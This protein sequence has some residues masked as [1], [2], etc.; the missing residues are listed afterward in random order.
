LYFDF[1]GCW[2]AAVVSFDYKKTPKGLAHA[3]EA[4]FT[5]VAIDI[6]S[7][8]ALGNNKA[9]QQAARELENTIDGV[10]GP[11]T[12][13]LKSRVNDAVLNPTGDGYFLGF[14]EERITDG[15]VLKYA[16][17]ISN[18]LKERKLPVR[19]GINK[20]YCFVYR[21]LNDKLNMCGWG[22]IDAERVMSF[23][24][25]N[26][27]LCTREFVKAYVDRHPDTKSLFHE[28]GSLTSKGRK[29][30]V[31]NYYKNHTYGSGKRPKKR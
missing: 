4:Q 23:G 19:M 30:D 13:D 6:V 25:K 7:F 15:E 11:V 5:I 18:S 27:I 1:Y 12:W 14:L 16:T 20:G 8:T 2:G 9:F 22:I 31:F 28:I 10:L 29:I 26:H 17:L 3:K 24:K 21:D